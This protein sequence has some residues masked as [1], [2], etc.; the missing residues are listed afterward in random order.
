M[1]G[2]D[3]TLLLVICVDPRGRGRRPRCALNSEASKLSIVK[4]SLVV[5]RRGVD[6]TSVHYL[7]QRSA[8]PPGRP[9][10]APTGTPR[11][12]PRLSAPRGAHR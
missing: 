3:S 6:G 1:N 4:A 2:L 7:G 12:T 5:Q 11:G 8:R 9:G 10:E